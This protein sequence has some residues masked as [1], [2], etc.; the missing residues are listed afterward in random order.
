MPPGWTHNPAPISLLTLSCPQ[1]PSF[2]MKGDQSAQPVM[3]LHFLPF[4]S[5]KGR[6]GFLPF[7]PPGLSAPGGSSSSLGSMEGETESS[8]Q[9]DPTEAI[10]VAG[11][12]QLLSLPQRQSSDSPLLCSHPV[13]VSC[14]ITVH[15]TTWC[16]SRG[17]PRSRTWAKQS[18]LTLEEARWHT[19][20]VSCAHQRGLSRLRSP[21]G[22]DPT[23]FRSWPCPQLFSLPLSGKEGKE[24]R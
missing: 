20:A 14:P 12:Q 13:W 16:P 15:Q 17:S 10:R 4:L 22:Q 1:P 3:P 24:A 21:L 6:A 8:W 18:R 9:Q 23:V 11:F 19:C 2:Y 7:P 5:F